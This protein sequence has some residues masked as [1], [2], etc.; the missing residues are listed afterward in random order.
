[1]ASVR[2]G[3]LALWLLPLLAGGC[4]VTDDYFIDES[5]SGGAGALSSGSAGV[6]GRPNGGAPDAGG[7][8]FGGE[9]GESGNDAGEEPPSEAGAP[10]AGGGASSATCSPRTERC[11][12]HDDN[13]NEVIDEQACN[14]MSAGTLGC[15]GFVINGREDHGY[16]LCTEVTRD[17]AHARDACRAQGM[18]LVWLESAAENDAVF[19]TVSAI[20]AGLEVWL[21]ATD[22][23]A[24]G[25]WGW[26]GQGGM[27]FWGGNEYGN[28]VGDAYTAWAR[29]TP[30]DSQEAGPEGEDC[31]VL[32]PAEA[33]WGDRACT[34]K[35]AY[36]CEEPELPTEP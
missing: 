11:N 35:Y 34:T 4:P 23:E 30:N 22:Q 5:G 2:A 13:C 1:M 6:P 33:T 12:G 15:S 3:W 19:K 28:P 25:T 17:Y 20:Q 21:G 26:D 18:R 32:M 31:A 9:T 7:S 24:E 29:G 27:V 36:L 16:M 14:S 10:A 8:S